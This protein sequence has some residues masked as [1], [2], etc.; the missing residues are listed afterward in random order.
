MAEENVNA[1]SLKDWA[2][3]AKN[4]EANQNAAGNGSGG[5]GA[6]AVNL[7][8]SAKGV[9][10]SLVSSVG[11]SASSAGGSDSS[12]GGAVNNSD[13]VSGG[14]QND[15]SKAKNDTDQVLKR[16]LNEKGKSRL[17]NKNDKLNSA[18]QNPGSAAEKLQQDMNS[19]GGGVS[20]KGDNGNGAAAKAAGSKGAKGIATGK[21]SGKMAKGGKATGAADKKAFTS[22]ISAIASNPIILAIIG[23]VVLL[24]VLIL[25]L[26]TMVED[27][28]NKQSGN[29]AGNT[30][31][32]NSEQLN[33]IAQTWTGMYYQKYSEMSVYANVD[34]SHVKNPDIA[35][36]DSSGEYVDGC[37]GMSYQ[38]LTSVDP[39]SIDET[40]LYQEGTQDWIDKKIQDIN[41]SEKYLQLSAGSLLELDSKLN[42][43]F[44]NPEQFIRP[45]YTNCFADDF[46][47]DDTSNDKD[48]DGKVTW[49]DCQVQNTDEDGNAVDMVADDDSNN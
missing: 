21:T 11:N 18:G 33:S 9:G 4:T 37:S 43:G 15:M 30:T 24:I 44:M 8:K 28:E 19:V 31:P 45:T 6:K 41:G 32:A 23:L 7:A 29:Y 35:G 39:H 10:D 34:L 49:K 26:G 38:D 22:L 40:K 42:D 46:D 47:W 12:Y 16:F 13:D 20:G 48:G 3:A 5:K 1:E 2:P 25:F 36:C 14:I 27:Q 17:Q